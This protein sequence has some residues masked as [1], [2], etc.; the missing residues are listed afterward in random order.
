M[1]IAAKLT[2]IASIIYF[3]YNMSEIL[4]TYEKSCEK[5]DTFKKLKQESESS[6]ASLR[7]SNLLLSILMTVV[8]VALIYSSGIAFWVTLVVAVKCLLTLF[9]S[10]KSLVKIL[11]SDILPKKIFLW[12]K[13][14][15]AFNAFF[16]LAIAIIVVV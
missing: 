5:V 4:S 11:H 2:L 15:A 3:G 9:C 6:E 10:D 16:G 14:D 13:V 7:R 1:D 8:F 12:T